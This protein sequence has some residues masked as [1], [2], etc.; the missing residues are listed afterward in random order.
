FSLYLEEHK[1]LSEIRSSIFHFFG[2]S[3]KVLSDQ[4]ELKQQ[5]TLID[6]SE[7][8]LCACNAQAKIKSTIEKFCFLDIDQKVENF[9]SYAEIFLTKDGLKRKISSI[10]EGDILHAHQEKIYFINGY[11]NC[12]KSAEQNFALI[13]LSKSVFHIY[14]NICRKSEALDYDFLLIQALQLL[15]KS[16]CKF[17]MRNE[18]HHLLIDEAQDL[19]EIQWRIIYLLSEDFFSGIDIHGSQSTIFIV[20][21]QKQSIFSFQGAEPSLMID[22]RD[23]YTNAAKYASAKWSL[24][25]INVSYRCADNILQNV[26]TIFCMPNMQRALLLEKPVCHIAYNAGGI[27]SCIADDSSE[28]ENKE[29]DKKEDALWKLPYERNIQNDDNRQVQITKNIAC[30]IKKWRDSK[31]K[32]AGMQRAILFADIMIIIRKRGSIYNKILSALREFEIPSMS[33]M[34]RN[35]LSE[36][37]AEDL[38]SLCK[39]CAYPFDDINLAGLLKSPFFQIQEEDL[40]NI[41]KL[42][43][44][45]IWE[46]LNTSD[47]HLEVVNILSDFLNIAKERSV[48]GFLYHILYE[49]FYIKRIE[50]NVGSYAHLVCEAFLDQALSFTQEQCG[51]IFSF[52]EWIQMEDPKFTE[53]NNEK[54]AVRITTAHSAKGLES[55]IVII[56]D[57]GQLYIGKKDDIIW[58]KNYPILNSAIYQ[59]NLISKKLKL[60]NTNAKKDEEMRL[61][62]VALTRA[63]QEL[64]LFGSE[65]SSNDSWYGICK[66]IISDAK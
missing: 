10:K 41:C 51:S 6:W 32:I 19:S 29:A 1:C 5:I 58:H 14:E 34:G 52:I 22:A 35:L 40:M 24:E 54:D 16:N 9:A 50:E 49:K 45:S 53:N 65:R 61:L 62:Y 56:A 18:I 26:D 55:N 11:I 48:F 27:F 20:G 3:H 33:Y 63:K 8:S 30:T 13:C 25:E 60:L 46:Y 59:N 47:L 12:I 21:D 38:L 43:N 39:F 23:H 31:R 28:E 7:I 64:Y 57:A 17:I 42:R 4:E 37:A 44:K 36:I 15:S 2:I 66:N